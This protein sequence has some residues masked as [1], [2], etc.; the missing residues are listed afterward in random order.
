MAA[1]GGT[2]RR[3]ITQMGGH[4]LRKTIVACAVTA[5]AVGAGTATA[6]QLITGKQIKDGSVTGADIRNGSLTGKEIES[7]SIQLSDLSQQV[8]AELAKAGTPGATGKD[9]AAGAT[10][11]KGDTGDAGATGPKGDKG[12]TGAPGKDA[13]VAVMKLDGTQGWTKREGTDNGSDNGTAALLDGRLVL[14]EPDGAAFSGVTFNAPAGT[15]LA[16]ITALVYSEKASGGIDGYNAPYF[17]IF[18]NPDA[19][20]DAQDAVIYSPSTQSGGP[21]T[22]EQFRRHNVLDG[23]VRYNDDAGAP[24]SEINWAALIA[25]HGGDQVQSVRIQAGDAGAN[26]ADSVATVDHV[27]LGFGNTLTAYDFGG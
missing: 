17:R 5:L 12:D 16:D 21:G 9:G 14:T 15:T 7:G 13:M 26:S 22:T 2:F 11:P 4:V 18:L 1:R 6:A 10:G 20:G 3:F 8:R 27:T 23:T 19:N 24:D 25:A